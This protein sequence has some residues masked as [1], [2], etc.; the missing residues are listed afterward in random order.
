MIH[1]REHKQIIMVIINSMIWDTFIHV[2]IIVDV[3][4]AVRFIRF[5]PTKAIYTF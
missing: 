1:D 2:Y 4:A 5:D 3:A